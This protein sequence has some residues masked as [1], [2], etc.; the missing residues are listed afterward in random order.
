MKNLLMEY[1]KM[2]KSSPHIDEILQGFTD[3][4]AE[5]EAII[6]S[7]REKEIL[8]LPEKLTNKEVGNQLFI[9]EKTVK[10][11]ITNINKKLN[12]HSKLEAISKAKNLELI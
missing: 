11:H 4:V 12:V 7:E 8:L 5:E 9:A 6:L 2:V 3:K 1:K 10:S